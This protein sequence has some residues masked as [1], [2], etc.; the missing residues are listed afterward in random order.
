MIIDILEHIRWEPRI[1]SALPMKPTARCPARFICE[2]DGK[3]FLVVIATTDIQK[4]YLKRSIYMQ[5]EFFPEFHEYFVFNMPILYGE[6][7][8]EFYVIYEYFNH[9]KWS[10]KTLSPVRCLQR[11]HKKFA[12]EYEMTPDI[13]RKI[14]D[15]F[16]SAWPESLHEAI[17]SLDLFN[18]YFDE[19]GKMGT[20]KIFKEHGDFTANNILCNKDE[21]WLMDFEFA[22]SFQI[23]GFDI[24]DYF[25]TNSS[26][27]LCK[28][29][30]WMLDVGCWMLD[31][32]HEL[33]DTINILCCTT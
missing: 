28:T 1:K 26:S 12:D 11:I 13:F 20:V 23:I 3:E 8:N 18:D 6:L 4:F 31:V 33:E 19:V 15:D 29:L 10:K 21:F 27:I 14:Q 32:R 2:H 22:R 16:L 7:M 17:K 30:C 25:R 24:F 9:L 5:E